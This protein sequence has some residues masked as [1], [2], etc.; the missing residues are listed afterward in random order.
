MVFPLNILFGSGVGFALGL[1][2]G[3]G[4]LLAVPILVYGLSMAPRE[5][6]AVSL[7][8]VGAIALIGAI[9]KIKSSQVEFRAGVLFALAGIARAPIGVVLAGRMPETA[10]LTLFSGFTIS[11]A[12]LM[13]RKASKIGGDYRDERESSGGWTCQRAED[14]TLL[15]RPQCSIA[16]G[17]VS[18][19]YSEQD[20]VLVND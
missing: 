2:G 4:S 14:G 5:A 1:T 17:I 8:S 9:S 3:G 10:L 19:A 16:L 20:S 15:E 11:L 12:I 6:F 18:R 13:W 7:A